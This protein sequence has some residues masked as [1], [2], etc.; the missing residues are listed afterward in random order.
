MSQ[1]VARAIDRPSPLLVRF[2]I[3]GPEHMKQ[4]ELDPAQQPSIW[5]LDGGSG[6]PGGL[7]PV[8]VICPLACLETTC[9]CGGPSLACRP[10][11]AAELGGS[12]P[13]RS[14]LATLR[15][16]P[17]VSP[18]RRNRKRGARLAT[19]QLRRS[20]WLLAD[21]CHLLGDC[22]IFAQASESVPAVTYLIA[23]VTRSPHATTRALRILPLRTTSEPVHRLR[24]FNTDSLA[25]HHLVLLAGPTR[26][27]SAWASS[28][29]HSPAG[30]VDDQVLVDPE[31]AQITVR[32]RVMLRDG[33]EITPGLRG[34]EESRPSRPA[35]TPR[36]RG[37]PSIHGRDSP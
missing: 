31:N 24:D 4:V 33:H 18:P 11:W 8:L 19:G 9:A 21:R 20:R 28:H 5:W 14:E 15:Q 36:L 25:L 16:V 23:L 26:W 32:D 2:N 29:D 27:V 34:S 37:E 7:W 3:G 10:T 12:A 22:Q 6:W 35:T 30:D 13:W 1:K 17:P